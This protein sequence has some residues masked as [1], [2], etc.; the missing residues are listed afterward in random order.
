MGIEEPLVEEIEEKKKEVVKKP[1]KPRIKKVSVPKPKKIEIKT[2][3]EV[4]KEKTEPIAEL[5]LEPQKSPEE[6]EA[7]K[8]EEDEEPKEK[9]P[10]FGAE[11]EGQL[12]VDVYQT[13]K[14]LVIQSAIAG[15]KP[16]N[17][18]ISIEKDVVSIKGAREK[19]SQEEGDYFAKECFW[20]PFSREIIL[21]AEVDPN[22]AE[23]SMKDGVLIIRIPKIL[24][25]KKRKITVRV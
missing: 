15:V 17:L 21:P 22:Q 11:P 14:D 2:P 8:K 10:D 4:K 24:R 5:S 13:E 12:A 1:M 6:P 9:W 3:S 20:G 18:D 23:A 19:P 25:D 16:E 7:A